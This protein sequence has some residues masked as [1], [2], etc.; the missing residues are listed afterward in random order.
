MPVDLLWA[1]KDYLLR[2]VE[3]YKVYKGLLSVFGRRR[4]RHGWG[5]TRGQSDGNLS[6]IV[7]VI[8]DY[9]TVRVSKGHYGL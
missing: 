6:G 8:Q 4:R 1:M 9:E 3:G 7:R 2:V 5:R